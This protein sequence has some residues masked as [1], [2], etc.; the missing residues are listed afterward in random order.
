MQVVYNP[1]NT[2]VN[3]NTPSVPAGVFRQPSYTR[4]SFTPI[5]RESGASF[6]SAGSF[7]S[8]IDFPNIEHSNSGSVASSAASSSPHIKKPFAIRQQ[9]SMI[10]SIASSL[11]SSLRISPIP[12]DSKSA[13]RLSRTLPTPHRLLFRSPTVPSKTRSNRAKSNALPVMNWMTRQ[14]TPTPTRRH[15]RRLKN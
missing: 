2:L 15:R 7:D 1:N 4:K 9:P 8:S 6:S 3:N 11:P 14:I 13:T 10:R 5:H 12:V